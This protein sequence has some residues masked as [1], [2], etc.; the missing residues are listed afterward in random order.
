M[1]M[2]DKKNTRKRLFAVIVAAALM[3]IPLC[4][5]TAN[6]GEGSHVMETEDI[7]IATSADANTPDDEHQAK[8]DSEDT[9]YTSVSTYEELVAAIEQ[10]DDGTVIGI[11]CMIQ[12]PDGTDLGKPDYSVIL[13]RT[14]PEGWLTF[15]GNQSFVLNITFDG[16][17]ILSPYAILRSGCSSLTVKDCNL[18]NCN[19]KSDGAIRTGDGDILLIGCLFDNNTG[20]SGAH[21]RIEGKNATIENCTFTN[22]HARYRGGAIFNFA[23]DDT[24]LSGCVITGNTAD[25]NGGGIY[26]GSR[27]LS[28]TESKIH[29]NTAASE[30]DDL[31][32]MPKMNAPVFDDYQDVV[33][34]YEPDGLFP[35]D[36]ETREYFEDMLPDPGTVYY[37]TFREKNPE[38]E[39]PSI[40]LN[41]SEL[42]LNIGDS[43]TLA[44]TLQPEGADGNIEWNSSDSAVASVDDAGLVTAV[45]A[46]KTSVTATAGDVSAACL[47][48]VLPDMYTIDAEPSPAQGG[49]VSG[50]GDYEDGVSATVTAAPNAGF[51][52]LEWT[53]NGSQVSTDASYT[54]TVSNN[55]KLTAVF[56]PVPPSEQTGKPDSDSSDKDKPSNGNTSNDE[57]KPGGG[58]VSNDGDKPGNGNDSND[59]DV[60]TNVSCSVTAIIVFY[61]ENGKMISSVPQDRFDLSDGDSIS[62]SAI[63]PQSWHT[64]KIFILVDGTSGSKPEQLHI[65]YTASP[66]QP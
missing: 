20:N 61:D 11:D 45:S 1:N 43:D 10:A 63:A 27:N 37:R 18:I 24:S 62:L 16:N 41:T 35:N 26:S 64:W 13:R 5:F 30:A 22:G 36:W 17:N 7:S 54:F 48:T 28:I 49:T 2:K 46:G 51:R 34:L 60:V 4:A 47:V 57:N 29:G 52:F 19:G 50:A 8:E 44:A 12:C 66:V 38:Q 31:T 55:R 15:Q 9:L 33:R 23:F 21:L 14:G 42:V 32:L 6:G 56:E 40:T 59:G 53:E 25:I 58:N 3:I 65:S 39:P